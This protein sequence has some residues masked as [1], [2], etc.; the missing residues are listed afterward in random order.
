MSER[1][2]LL[3]VIP[4]DHPEEA[5][6]NLGELEQLVATYGGKVMERV[7]QHR[8]H[9]D[10]NTYIGR[11]KLEWLKEYVK[12]EEIDI[13]ILNAVAKTS[14]L[15]RL[16]KALW[17]VNTQIQVWDKVDLILHIFEQHAQTTEAKLQIE[18]AR[19]QQRGA[20]IY[21]LGGTVLSRQGGGI[22]TRGLGE[23][24]IEIERR[25][26]K[27]RVQFLKK[28]LKKRAKN[29]SQRIQDR[30][31]RGVFTTALVGYTSAGKTTLFNA[32]T[33]KQKT[34]HQGL[35]TT[36]D[37]VVGKVKFAKTPPVLVSD[38]IGFI[39]DLPP[40]LVEAFRSTL[41]E[42]LQARALLHVV[43]AASPKRD[44]KIAVVENILQELGV[45][46][47]P[48]L[49]LNKI[50]LLSEDDQLQLE[51]QYAD[52]QHFL[53]SAQT[54]AGIK[55]LKDWLQT[56]SLDTLQPLLNSEEKSET[57][58]AAEHEDR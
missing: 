12:D 13:V 47:I 54:G 41:Q 25:H 57:E 50:D 43:D 9:P 53:V 49:V 24:N 2:V 29:Q 26:M 32:L 48:I 36:L 3:Q 4:H 58:T 21:G 8:P 44:D 38:T 51:K 5:L 30:Q 33:N 20:R 35:F 52:R 22:G 19:I 31:N 55:K 11:G 28:E 27:Q 34:T 17:E 10:P 42:S 37:S 6:A 15:F 23:T 40:A 45:E 56:S 46:V 1:C 18:L 14:Q 39:E 7:T 16:E